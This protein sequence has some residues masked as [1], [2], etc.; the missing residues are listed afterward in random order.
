MQQPIQRIL[1][2]F[3]LFL[4]INF[5]ASAKNSLSFNQ[6]LSI[7]ANKISFFEIDVGSGSLNVKGDN[8]N[9][10]E[11][12]ATIKSKKYS[13]VRDLQEAFESKMRFTLENSG[14]KAK[15]KAGNKKTSGFNFKNPNIQIDLEVIVPNNMN[16]FIDDGSGSMYIADINGDVEIDDGSGSLEIE[17]IR[18]DLLIDDGSGSQK[19]TNIDGNVV[20]DDGSGSIDMKYIT[21]N[22]TIDDG[23]GSINIEELAGRFKLIDGGS[24]KIYVNGQKWIE[25][26]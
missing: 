25:K 8:I 21:G 24:G 1:I 7:D 18:G 15:L 4:L 6:N 9:Q 20:V 14:S 17:N 10:I 12:R 19:I 23:S 11:V 5:T 22:A 3:S 26:D 2:I 13:D 16:L